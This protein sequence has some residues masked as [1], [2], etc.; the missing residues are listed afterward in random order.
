MLSIHESHSIGFRDLFS[1][2][3]M[4][5]IGGVGMIGL[6]LRSLSADSPLAAAEAATSSLFG[7]AK[8]IIYLFLAGQ[9]ITV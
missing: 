5:R 2:R 7:R 8:N 9:T 1:R 6:S 4:L 3:E